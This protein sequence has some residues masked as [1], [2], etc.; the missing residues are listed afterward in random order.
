VVLMRWR[1]GAEDEVMPDPLPSVRTPPAGKDPSSDSGDGN[2]PAS[3]TTSTTTSTAGPE[4]KVSGIAS[5]S[6]L[7]RVDTFHS[8][9]RPT[10]QPILTD[11][12]SSLTG[13]T[14]VCQLP[15]T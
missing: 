6:R 14:Q 10:W 15:R 8:Y 1:E 4:S 5:S 2:A 12:C 11:F 9:V 13:I 7:E 3:T